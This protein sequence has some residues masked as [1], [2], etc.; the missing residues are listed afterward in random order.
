MIMLDDSP[1]GLNQ[2]FEESYPDPNVHPVDNLGLFPMG[3]R[4]SDF[5]FTLWS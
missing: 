3:V 5:F 2:P 1:Y 4:E